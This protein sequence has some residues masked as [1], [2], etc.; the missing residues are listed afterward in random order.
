MLIVSQH[1]AEIVA[2]QT[3]VVEWLG[4]CVGLWL[5]NNVVSVNAIS[6]DLQ[7]AGISKFVYDDGVV[8]GRYQSVNTLF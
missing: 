2:H 8:Q 6:Q 3:E 4:T 1:T 5:V 7:K